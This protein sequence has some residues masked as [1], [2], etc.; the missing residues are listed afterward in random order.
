MQSAMKFREYRDT[1]PVL[2]PDGIVSIDIDPLSGMPATAACPSA[3]AEVYISGSQPLGSC[4]LHGG[5]RMMT[6]VTG[7]DTS[8]A[9]TSAQPPAEA[10]PRITGSGPDSLQPATAA[11]RAARQETTETA[12]DTE[13]AAPEQPKKEK[14]SLFRRLIGVFK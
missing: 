4:P 13:A 12:G 11:R 9:A 1:K 5:G 7:W 10:T 2:A 6:H 8:P 14:K 3:R